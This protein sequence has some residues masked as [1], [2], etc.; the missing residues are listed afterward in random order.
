MY[1]AVA[2]TVTLGARCH[3]LHVKN[4]GMTSSK[5]RPPPLAPISRPV[6]VMSDPVTFISVHPAR[7]LV[8][9]VAAVLFWAT[10]LDPAGR[11]PPRFRWRKRLRDIGRRRPRI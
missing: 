10:L 4:L 2:A 11:D 7:S 9:V 8:T 1:E 6:S 3:R 5:L